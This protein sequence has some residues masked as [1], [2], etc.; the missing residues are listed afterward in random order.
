MVENLHRMQLPREVV[1]GKNT[2]DQIGVICK[3]LDF[4]KSGLIVMGPKTMEIAGRKAMDILTQEG[5]KIDHLVVTSC[6][7]KDIVFV[8]EKIEEL[9]PQVVLGIGGGTKI[10]AAKISAS[11]KDTPFISVPTTASHDGI[12][13]P[14]V[15]LKGLDKP[16]SLMAQAPM[17]IVADTNIII[18][19]S[20]RFIA[21]GCADVI[22]KLTS[23][24][25]WKLAHEVIDE[26]YGEYAAN[27]ALMSARLMMKNARLL[28]TD[29]EQ[30]L[31]VLLEALISCGVA[32][33]IAGSSRPCSGSEHLFSHA[34]D[35]IAP[36]PAMHGEQCGV[37]TIMMARLH[38]INWRRVRDT[39]KLAGAPT[40]A[41]DLGLEPEHIIEALVHAQE[42]R[43]DRYTILDERTLTPETAK[44]LAKTTG[45][46]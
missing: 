25:D 15:S 18:N 27:L 29:K 14:L 33:S 44:K 7:I 23:V 19:S 5:L 31:R 17:A 36:K 40:T 24:K 45:V 10:D 28:T 46:I 11:H 8:E 30:G 34:L 21:S 42:I 16:Y 4:S 26:Y 13:S 2:I 41:Q 3:R 12:A 22:S 9:K 43:P 6:N 1:V 35:H 38:N 20:P 32:M 37:G 39:L